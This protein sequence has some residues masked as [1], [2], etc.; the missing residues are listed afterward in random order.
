MKDDLRTE[1][2]FKWQIHRSIYR[3]ANHVNSKIDLH[4]LGHTTQDCSYI[5]HGSFIEFNMATEETNVAFE[6][7]IPA[8]FI[9]SLE[10][11]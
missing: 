10:H 1:L 6:A 8:D 11:L 3:V 2:N 4:F 9:Q 5:I 7:V